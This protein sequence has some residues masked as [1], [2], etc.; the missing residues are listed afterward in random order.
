MQT[1]MLGAA[2]GLFITA[3]LVFL[4]E[5]LDDTLKTPDEIKAF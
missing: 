5:F 3:A 1:A 4:I 2:I